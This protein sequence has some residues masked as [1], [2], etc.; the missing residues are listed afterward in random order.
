[1]S[2]MIALPSRGGYPECLKNTARKSAGVGQTDDPLRKETLRLGNLIGCA[3]SAMGM[4][5]PGNRL[6]VIRGE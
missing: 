5:V 3:S 4:D 1:M 2:E 6:K